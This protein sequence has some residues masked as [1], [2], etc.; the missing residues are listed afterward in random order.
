M[1][2]RISMARALA[3]PGAGDP[4]DDRRPEEAPD[5]RWCSD[6]DEIE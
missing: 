2:H 3:A 4:V 1:H 6:F 5:G